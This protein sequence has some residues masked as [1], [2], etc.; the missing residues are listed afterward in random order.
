MLKRWKISKYFMTRRNVS[1]KFNRWY[2]ITVSRNNDSYVTS[3]FIYIVYHLCCNSHIR[4]F[5]LKSMY[6]SATMRA[7]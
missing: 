5:F 4:F 6:N 2:H 3:S 7:T 1:D